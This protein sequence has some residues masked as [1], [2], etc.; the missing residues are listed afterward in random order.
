[1][2]RFKKKTFKPEW[3]V[4]P[5]LALLWFQFSSWQAVWS[6]VVLTG[7]Y[8]WCVSIPWRRMFRRIFFMK[9]KKW[10]THVF[11]YFA[12]LSLLG[13]GV[14]V[15]IVWYKFHSLTLIT[16]FALVAA[17][18]FLLDRWTYGKKMKKR[19]ERQY[20]I[21]FQ[22]FRPLRAPR[23][24]F[25]LYAL[26]WGVALYLLHASKSD[27]VLQ[28]PWQA[29]SSY[30]PLLL[31]ALTAVLG[32]LL[33]A[34]YKTKTL[35]LFV[36]L[37]SFLIHAFLPLSHVLPWGG[38]V[39]RTVGIESKIASG[40]PIY[41][42]L[43]G[44]QVEW[45]T[46]GPFDVPRIFTAPHKYVY[47]QLWG[48]SL[49][50]S[51]GIGFDELQ[52]QI[53]LVPLLWSLVMPIIFFRLGAM[54]F[55]SPRYGLWF[56]ALTLVPFSLQALGGLTL[57]VSLG[58]ISFFFTLM[59]WLQYV[60]EGVAWQRG[61]ALLFSVLLLFGYSLY[62]ILMLALILF[63]GALFGVQKLRS[64]LA[65]KSVLTVTG[66]AS[67]CV[68]PAVELV[69]K[70]SYIQEQVPL[71][72]NLKQLAGQFSG[73]FYATMIRP[74]DI[75]SGNIV[76]NHTPDWAFVE[77]VFTNW[78][79]HLVFL[80]IAMFFG[81][82][83]SLVHLLLEERRKEWYVL[84]S[85]FLM[86]AGGYLVSWGVFAGDLSFARRLDP[87]L[88]VLF[89]LF[90]CAGWHVFVQKLSFAWPASIRSISYMCIVLFLSWST[91]T[92]AMS[93]PDMRVLAASEY[94][95]AQVAFD[96]VGGQ[97]SYCIIADTWPLLAL[98]SVSAANIIGG[99]F[100]IDY[101]FAQPERVVL[102]QA[103]LDD[104]RG[105]IL[106]VAREATGTSPCQVIVDTSMFDEE[107]MAQLSEILE[108]DV[109]V[110]GS[111]LIGKGRLKTEE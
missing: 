101:Q 75:V 99:G 35:L 42:V 15:S 16:V 45:I 31:F 77:S 100:P 67:V 10:T 111:F 108:E 96:M 61:I 105:S 14:S 80:M 28:S 62:A 52:V 102:Y 29:I 81:I 48:T 41:P 104:P 98:E 87:T 109:A 25:V 22:K 74:H 38:D 13:Y 43:F 50:A 36:I 8:L 21:R 73:W 39:W 49:I 51:E 76:F 30:Y 34:K 93:G 70:S 57:A 5:V 72:A 86:V 83:I 6:G 32:V 82:C 68:I 60:R 106:E 12:V 71:L 7:A 91:V 47:G 95:A 53:W 4:L 1:M 110:S 58:T 33:V 40:E 17:L 92:I 20:D 19:V 65:Q 90:A 85:L 11:A 44:E 97:E 89:V 107:K 24:L 54:L 9:E 64:S 66:F 79:Y 78:R 23:M 18:S 103:L 46:V 37:H 27:V 26:G 84:G 59:L 56:S 3:L 69:S 88:A 55:G 63:T 2:K 94:Q